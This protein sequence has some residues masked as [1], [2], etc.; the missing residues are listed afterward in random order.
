[1]SDA[2]K[3]TETAPVV[4]EIETT[5]ETRNAEG[6]TWHAAKLPVWVRNDRLVPVPVTPPVVVVPPPQPGPRSYLTGLNTL[7][8]H[9]LARQEAERGCK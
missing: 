3:L 8:N 9:N 1:M 5:G 4:T 6:H 2:A 7:G